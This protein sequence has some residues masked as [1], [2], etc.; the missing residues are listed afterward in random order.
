MPS[1]WKTHQIPVIG[2]LNNHAALPQRPPVKEFHSLS[3]VPEYSPEYRPEAVIIPPTHRGGFDDDK[4][5]IHTIP[6]PNLS[7]A[8]K[9][10]N[11]VEGKAVE[12]NHEDSSHRR[13]FES[14]YNINFP[15]K[16]LLPI[17]I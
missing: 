8:D 3:K 1:G 16:K 15:G 4:G 13:P 10:Y 2:V 5:P 14:N 11:L 9:P 12:A 17:V 6:A 7:P